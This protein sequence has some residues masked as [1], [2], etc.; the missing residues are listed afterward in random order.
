MTDTDARIEETL[1]ALRRGEK[2]PCPWCGAEHS[3]HSLLR[4]SSSALV[5]HWYCGS[6]VEYVDDYRSMQR[7]ETCYRREI[8]AQSA[9]IAALRA[10]LAGAGQGS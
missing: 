8:A 7:Y 4:G 9:T 3:D 5:D 6:S 10:A 2:P 1:A